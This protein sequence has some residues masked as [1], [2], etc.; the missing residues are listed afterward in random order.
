M[1]Q[2]ERLIWYVIHL[3]G[4]ASNSLC[5]KED[6]FDTRETGKHSPSRAQHGGDG[7]TDMGGACHLQRP[8]QALAMG[9]FGMW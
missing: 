8:R 3:L 5:W 4:Q 2:I 1:E 7:P 9:K 6:P